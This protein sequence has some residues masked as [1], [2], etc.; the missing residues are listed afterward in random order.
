[1]QSLL[2]KF[3]AKSSRRVEIRDLRDVRP[4][5]RSEPTIQEA[6]DAER[7]ELSTEAAQDA[8]FART[9]G[10]AHGDPDDRERPDQTR[11]QTRPPLEARR[12]ASRL[13][14]ESVTE[15][16]RRGREAAAGAL[17]AIARQARTQGLT[18]YQGLLDSNC[19]R[20]TN[21]YTL[22]ASEASR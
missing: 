17:P 9:T 4:L 8:E 20:D 15:R 10:Q 21:E 7:L 3:L 14:G 2:R 16:R 13:H 1:V 11:V 5:Y 12:R 18:V 22:L 19:L 6:H